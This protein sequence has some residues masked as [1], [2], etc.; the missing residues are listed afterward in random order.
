MKNFR[1][2]IV[3]SYEEEISDTIGNKT[4]NEA[5]EDIIPFDSDIVESYETFS[6][7][8]NEEYDNGVKE[9]SV[10]IGQFHAL[11]NAGMSSKLATVVMSWIREDKLNKDNIAMQLEIAKQENIR[12]KK[13]IL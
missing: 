3:D 1:D 9:A 2:V 11:I 10:Y 12:A 4:M 5:V 7:S 6:C 13:E 8:N